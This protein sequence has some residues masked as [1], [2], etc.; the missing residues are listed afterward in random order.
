M[1]GLKL[2]QLNRFWEFKFITEWNITLLL[3]IL[4]ANHSNPREEQPT[5]QPERQM[6]KYEWFETS[7]VKSVLEI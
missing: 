6:C 7:T 3:F 1:N 5:A 4:L 2:Q